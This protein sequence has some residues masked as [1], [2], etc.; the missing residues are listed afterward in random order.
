MKTILYDIQGN[1]KKEIDLPHIFNSKI[2]EDM[3]HKLFEAEKF[4][5]ISPYSPNPEAGKRHSASGT[6]SHRRHNWK[7]HYGMGISRVPRKTMWRRGTQFFWIG[8]E[9]SSARGGRR[10]HP[11]RVYKRLRK[12]NKKEVEQAMH[13]AIAA[14]SNPAYLQKRYE[15][16]SKIESIP[17][18]I[19]SSD[20]MK[21][22]DIFNVLKIILKENIKI[23]I[24][25]KTIRAGKGKFRGR[26]YYSNAGLL[27]I[28][29]KNEEIKIKG[30]D[31]KTPQ[32]LVISDLYPL[33]RLTVFTEKSLEELK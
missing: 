9:I 32:E 31:I 20:K 2:R 10:A 1:K 17:I 12:I 14:T 25:N 15:S 11:P 24:K 8:A 16:I 30:I 28:K 7:G 29:S 23:A 6:I 18:I 27:L 21:T 13:S 26:K 33:G 4:R 22:K 3:V 19:E 5:A